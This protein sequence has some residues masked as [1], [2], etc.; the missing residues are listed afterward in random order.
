MAGIGDDEQ[1]LVPWHRIWLADCIISSGL[2]LYHILVSCL[3]EVTGMGFLA[4]HDEHRRTYLID[5]IKEARIGIC[6]TAKGVPTVVAVAR[7]RMV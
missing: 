2:T 5:L 6:L 1:L 4:M 7:T 3:A